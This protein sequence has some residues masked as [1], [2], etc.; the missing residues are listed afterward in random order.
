MGANTNEYQ[1]KYMKEYI[2]IS[3][4]ITCSLCGFSYK[5]VYKHNHNKSNAH[6]SLSNFINN[7]ETLL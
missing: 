4:K 5:L 1:K 3:P 7:F 6:K 2:K